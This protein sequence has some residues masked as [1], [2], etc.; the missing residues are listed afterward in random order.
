MSSLHP[1]GLR[2]IV[3]RSHEGAF[4][5][6]EGS[7]FDQVLAASTPTAIHP[8]LRVVH[9]QAMSLPAEAEDGLPWTNTETLWVILPVH[10][11]AVLH[12]QAG[13]EAAAIM[14]LYRLIVKA[15]DDPQAVS[16]EEL[17]DLDARLD[18][19]NLNDSETRRRSLMT[20]RRG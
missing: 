4:G 5:P 19:L 12:V 18:E 6:S 11:E 3:N 1:A 17:A 14:F 9:P 10:A 16:R 13:G 20:R 8:L 7:V 2:D 15:G